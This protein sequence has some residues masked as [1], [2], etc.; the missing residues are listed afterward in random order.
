M[1]DDIIETLRVSLRARCAEAAERLPQ[2]LPG[3]NAAACGATIVET[4]SRALLLAKRWRRDGSCTDYDRVRRVNLPPV[5]LDDLD[6][7]ARLLERLVGRPR[8]CIVRAAIAD[9]SRVA[10]VRR[11]LHPDP[12]TDEAATLVE[13]PRRWCA[14]DLDNVPLPAGA[15]PR[16]LSACARHALALLPAAFR[17]ARCIVQATS[18]HGIKPGARLR[19]WFWLSRPTL[20]A[21]LQRWLTGFPVDASCFRAAQPH[22]TA[23]PL[24]DGRPDPLPRRLALLPGAE[25]VEVPPLAALRPPPPPPRPT[26][27]GDTG[28]GARA[29]AWATREI[30]RQREGARHDSA[31]RIA[32]WLYGLARVGRL[33]AETIAPA[34]AAGLVEAGKTESEARAICRYIAAKEGAR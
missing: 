9:P 21:E 1:R 32:G 19:L 27:A 4:A 15:A 6:A 11:L 17:A 8:C 12:D 5:A 25:A 18:G 24:F 10:G 7:L 26:R 13:V 22:Y 34:I 28:D 2:P 20:G 16:D 14:L 29:L 33:Q 3:R 30:A 23:A 31:L